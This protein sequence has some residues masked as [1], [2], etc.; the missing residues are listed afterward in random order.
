MLLMLLMLLILL[1]LLMLLLPLVLLPAVVAVHC[2]PGGLLETPHYPLEEHHRVGGNLGELSDR[3][4]RRQRGE[5]E[6]CWLWGGYNWF[7]GVAIFVQVGLR[8]SSWLVN[9]RFRLLRL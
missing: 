2:L 7:S 1:L 4:S 5:L 9:I 8:S 3:G 6:Q